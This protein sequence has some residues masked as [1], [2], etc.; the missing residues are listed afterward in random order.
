MKSVLDSNILIDYLNGVSESA[1]T[2]AGL[3]TAIISRVSWMEVMVGSVQ[4]PNEMLVRAFLEGFH[5][6]EIDSRLAEEAISLR[7]KLRLRLPD[8][9]ILATAHLQGCNLLTRNTRDFSPSWPEIR[10]P[11]HL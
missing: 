8:A 4:T 9:I 1:E 7:A 3:S 6:I 11:Y 2:I 10:V 5:I